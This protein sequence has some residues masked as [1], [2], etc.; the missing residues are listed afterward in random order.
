MQKKDLKKRENPRFSG[1]KKLFFAS[2]QH[3]GAH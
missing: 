1:F 3:L 2:W